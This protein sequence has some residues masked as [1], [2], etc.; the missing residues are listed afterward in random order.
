MISFEE[1]RS[2]DCRW[3][4]GENPILLCGARKIAGSSYCERHHAM[5]VRP[6]LTQAERQASREA[7]QRYTVTTFLKAA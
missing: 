2:G 4:I 6:P 5:S 7:R 1:L 3:P